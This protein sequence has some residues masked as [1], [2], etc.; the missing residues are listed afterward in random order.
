M[1]WHTGNNQVFY[2]PAPSVQWS[3]HEADIHLM[4]EG[5]EDESFLNALQPSRDALI[6][7][8]G[9]R[10]G[11]CHVV[12]NGYMYENGRATYSL[13]AS[14]QRTDFT[15]SM[16]VALGS[17]SADKLAELRARRLLLNENPYV[18]SRDINAITH[19]LFVGGQGTFFKVQESSFPGLYRQFGSDA[20]RFLG[21]AWITAVVQLKLSACVVE[22]VTLQLG[23]IRQGVS[24]GLNL[25]FRGR[26]KKQYQDRPPYE[27]SIEGTC[28]LA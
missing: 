1:L 12:D 10:V 18:P 17:T 2:V 25:A 6:I 14:V 16:E 27:M 13:R 15:P 24:M 4:P 19:E 7:G 11:I 5:P 20:Q 22:V 8:H 3:S 9:H 21:I 26:R 23:L 28:P